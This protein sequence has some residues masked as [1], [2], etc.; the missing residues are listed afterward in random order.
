MSFPQFKRIYILHA[1]LTFKSEQ[2]TNNLMT[3]I[4][5]GHQRK[6]DLGSLERNAAKEKSVFKIALTSVIHKRRNCG[7]YRVLAYKHF[8]QSTPSGSYK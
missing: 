1:T 7:T 3:R 6:V 5:N 4:T 2:I 8:L